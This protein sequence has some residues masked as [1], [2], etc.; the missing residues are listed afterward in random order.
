MHVAWFS[1][2]MGWYDDAMIGAG[3]LGL[4]IRA[5]FLDARVEI[6]A[7]SLYWFDPSNENN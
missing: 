1:C 3:K 5:N 6:D 4:T 7:L 2:L